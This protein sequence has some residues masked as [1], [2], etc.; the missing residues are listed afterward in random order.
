MMQPAQDS[1]QSSALFTE[2]PTETAVKIQGGWWGY[3]LTVRQLCATYDS[4]C[5]CNSSYNSAVV[6][7]NYHYGYY[8]Q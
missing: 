1:T 5:G 4:S 6:T 2:V 8:G 3:H 7:P